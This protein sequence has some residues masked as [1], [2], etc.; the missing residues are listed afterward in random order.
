MK[1]KY[2][3]EKNKNKEW[4]DKKLTKYKLEFSEDIK[5]LE[6]I[7]KYSDIPNYDLFKWLIISNSLWEIL[8]ESIF[9]LFSKYSLE[10]IKNW[11]GYEFPVDK[12]GVKA[13]KKN[14]EKNVNIREKIDI[15]NNLS[16]LLSDVTPS[17]IEE[18]QKILIDY[19][20]K[21]W[22]D[23]FY[24]QWIIKYKEEIQK[25]KEETQKEKEEIQKEEEEYRKKIDKARKKINNF[26]DKI[27]EELMNKYFPDKDNS[28]RLLDEAYNLIW[29]IEWDKEWNKRRKENIN[30]KIE[31]SKNII[32]S[33]PINQIKKLFSELKE[34]YKK[35]KEEL[36]LKLK[37]RNIDINSAEWQAEIKKLN[38]YKE[39]NRIYWAFKSF[40]PI[41]SQKVDTLIVWPPINQDIPITQIEKW[42]LENA[43]IN[44]TD[45][46]INWNI[47]FQ[48]W[49]DWI[50]KIW[51]LSKV[52][53]EIF[54]VTKN[55]FK[56]ETKLPK[57]P[58]ELNYKRKELSKKIIKN[59][60]KITNINISLNARIKNYEEKKQN[61]EDTFEIET[62]IEE[63]KNEIKKIKEESKKLIDNFMKEMSKYNEITRLEQEE[64]EKQ[65]K[66]T[67]KF[68]S[69]I[70]FDLI[71]Q[72][73]TNLLIKN[74]NISPKNYWFDAKID[75]ENW[76]LW[77][78][79][80]WDEYLTSEYRKTF[81]GLFIKSI[82]NPEM[83]WK[84]IFNRDNV[85]NES[86]VVDSSKLSLY[87]NTNWYKWLAA[88]DKMR[89]N[90]LQKSKEK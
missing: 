78:R 32:E 48:N 55:W 9:K 2:E 64:K 69:K 18:I 26:S 3:K 8:E 86:S 79:W 84:E 72:H 44:Y 87:L 70:G 11:I 56:L 1:N 82:W 42:Q 22:N 47:V 36:E 4:L 24:M 67:L 21:F 74:I 61:W 77:I 34:K 89:T 39:I 62:K 45:S 71:P 19:Q 16:K 5:W 66:E 14:I 7:S 38:S 73:I 57:I 43:G 27:V 15:Q 54:M 75:L 68:L 29:F 76:D 58:D 28:L 60:Q 25:E 41:L 80:Y 59:N 10:Q 30:K 13:M 40:S 33:V 31:E 35:E 83:D 46:K 17:N 52:P 88:L 85:V 53:P 81:M 23:E 20:K 50:W 65:Q 37:S 6:E 63:L 49:D 51:D 12:T 90:L